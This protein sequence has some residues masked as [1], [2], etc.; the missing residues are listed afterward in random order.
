[1]KKLNYSVKKKKIIPFDFVIEALSEKHPRTKPMF[2]C[3]A[4]YI[5]EKIVL[6]LRDRKK[7][8][9]DDGVWICTT[10]EHHES[11]RKIFPS[12]KSIDVFETAITGWQ[13]LPATA[14]DF[15]SSVMTACELILKND[16]RI[17]RVPISKNSRHK[18]K[19]NMHKQKTKPPRSVVR[20]KKKS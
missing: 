4:V 2:G 5:G 18:N 6:I 20:Q 15:E 1:M 10:V 7:P 16:P 19:I 8:I 9:Q 12:M 13:V 14:E 17:G 11:L 3:T